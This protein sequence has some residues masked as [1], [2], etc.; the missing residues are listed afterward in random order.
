MRIVLATG[1]P[2]KRQEIARI[3]V[4][5]GL[6]LILVDPPRPLP[7][8]VE[9]GT[10]LAENA[11]RKAVAVARAL[12]MATLAD[13][14]GLAI[15]A[16]NGEPGIH[17]ARWAGPECIAANNVAKAL[18]LLAGVPVERR[19]ARFLCVVAL[20][21]DPDAPPLLAEGRL[22]GHI[23]EAAAGAGG[24]GYDPIFYLPDRGCT[25][26]ELAEGEKNRLS[27][28]YRALAALGKILPR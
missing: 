10:S 14:T 28:R 2:H 15:D 12:G 5:L 3:L 20:C 25:L 11:T 7:E 13:D 4:E 9:D 21:V 26:A 24:F 8:V 19:S 27:H 17:A 16:L 22:E 18:R 6:P 1:N 23:A